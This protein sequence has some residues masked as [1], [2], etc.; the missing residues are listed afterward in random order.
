MTQVP[1]GMEKV[2]L[3]WQLVMDPEFEKH[4]CNCQV[5]AENPKNCPLHGHMFSELK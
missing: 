4:R 3:L 5:R 1:A 2:A